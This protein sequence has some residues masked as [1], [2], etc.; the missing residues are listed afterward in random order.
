MKP[1][2][3]ALMLLAIC[4]AQ[5]VVVV[6][7]TIVNT[8]LPSIGR[9]LGLPPGSLAW[10]VNAYLLL[11][12]GCLLLGGRLAD[13]L[14]RRR[15][16]IAGAALF[17]VSSLACGLAA[18]AGLLVAAR[19]LQG[20]AGALLSPAALSMLV[21]SFPEGPR[22]TR[23]LG[24]WAALLGLGAVTGLLAGGLIAQT[25][26]WRWIFYV[27]VPITVVVVAAAR[28]L[29]PAD[30]PRDAR[31]NLDIAGATFVTGGLLA[32]VSAIVQS[33]ERGSASGATI[34]GLAVGMLLLTLF[35]L[36]QTRAANP[37]IPRR[38]IARRTV[39]IANGATVLVA[40]GMF[41]MFFFASL[42]MQAVQ[43]WSPLRAGASSLAFTVG[44]GMSTGVA[45]RYLERTG[46]RR[47][48]AA[49]LVL[50]TVGLLLLSNLR[51][52]DG[53]WSALAPAMATVGLGMGLAFV[54]L[55]AL[56]TH[57]G[58]S[59]DANDASGTGVASEAGVASGLVNS[60]QQIGGALGIAVLVTVS[61]DR[62]AQA[63]ANGI[64]QPVALT[65]GFQAAFAGSAVLLIASALLVP[66][67]GRASRDGDQ[68]GPG[69]RPVRVRTPA[70]TR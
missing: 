16:F 11:F 37:L 65:E 6:D 41:A 45:T 55:T 38:V 26:G 24:A 22:R 25:V 23:A 57:I 21:T 40:A 20:F 47:L 36:R 10:V 30:A 50:A 63:L 60:S 17:G 27:N 52:G 67:L 59:D 1:L 33:Q 29:L 70:P 15:M 9:D 51:A 31:V 48:L 42:Y 44:F 4:L 58:A 53:Y 46:P 64:E 19:G 14:G 56:A 2:R 3:P 61:N 54:P 66:L 8:A 12:G 68:P 34:T 49:G 18:S 28:R 35:A 32:V 7:D 39:L 13:A 69:Q 5:F 62:T 43:G